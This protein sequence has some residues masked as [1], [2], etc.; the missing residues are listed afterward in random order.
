MNSMSISELIP[1]LEE[2]IGVSPGLFDRLDA[3]DDT[4]W[5]FIIKLHALIEAAISHLLTTELRRGELEKLFARMD[6]SNKQTGKAAFVEA[7]GLL[8]KPARTFMHSLSTLR[9]SLVHDVRNIDF[10]LEI[11]VS[12]MND[13]KKRQFISEF[14]L[15][16]TEVTI[17]V[18]QLY[19]SDP[20]SALWYSGMAF[21]GLVYL[22]ISPSI[23]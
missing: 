9:N 19:L 4:D 18:R 2:R 13:H 14:N 3:E 12:K 23:Y 10:N 6:I 5:S 17:D 11:Y 22:K 1:L 7:L 21:L 16:S 20:R 15:I 8:D